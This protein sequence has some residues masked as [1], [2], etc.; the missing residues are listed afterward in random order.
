MLW[1]KKNSYKEFDNEKK[2]PAARKFPPWASR[3]KARNSFLYSAV[4][5][6]FDFWTRINELS[7]FFFFKL[8]QF[9]LKKNNILAQNNEHLAKI[10]NP[11]NVKLQFANSHEKPNAKGL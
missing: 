11:S 2:I 7:L 5:C 6:L 10:W 3:L 1:P 8:M 9:D 4:L